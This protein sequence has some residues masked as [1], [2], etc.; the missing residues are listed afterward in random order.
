VRVRRIETVLQWVNDVEASKRWYADLLGVDTT[1]Y[2]AP[3]F[4]FAEHCYLILGQAAP[5]TGRGGTGVWFEVEN[6]DQAYREL[7]QRG[8]AFN[9]PPFDIPPGRLVTLKDPDGNIIGLID[10]SKGGMPGRT[11]D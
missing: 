4:K 3:Y 10:N 8:Y 1:P 7:T 9:E 11:Y 6:V 5:G 2:E